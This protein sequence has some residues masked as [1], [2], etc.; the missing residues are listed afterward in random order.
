[1]KKIQMMIS[2]FLVAVEWLIFSVILTLFPLLLG[3]IVKTLAGYK[4]ELVDIAPDCLLVGFSIACSV[5]N[6]VIDN[7]EI[8]SKSAKKILLG[9]ILA[10]AGACLYVYCGLFGNVNIPSTVSTIVSNSDLLSKVFKAMALFLLLF[11]FSSVILQM[12]SN[13]RENKE[14]KNGKS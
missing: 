8:I 3:I 6:C 14:E 10:F 5:L 13:Y 4:P 11:I 12:K 9:L 1:M 2:L 7:E